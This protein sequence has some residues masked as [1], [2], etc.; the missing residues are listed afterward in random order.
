MDTY[1][2][3]VVN[4][5]VHELRPLLL[6]LQVASVPPGFTGVG[7]DQAE[8]VI[9]RFRNQIRLLQLVLRQRS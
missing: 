8:D 5:V 6:E 3:G 4:G 7:V 9:R 1:E 2:Q